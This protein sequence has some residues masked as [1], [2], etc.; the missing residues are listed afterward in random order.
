MQMKS[1]EGDRWKYPDSRKSVHRH[2]GERPW[3]LWMTMF[4]AGVVNRECRLW[5]WAG[6]S[7][8]CYRVHFYKV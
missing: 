3:C 2:E 6:P 8:L 4:G 5:R 1:I 7:K